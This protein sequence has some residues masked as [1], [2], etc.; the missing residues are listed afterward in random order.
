MFFITIRTPFI[1]CSN[2]NRPHGN[3]SQDFTL[4]TILNSKSSI[5]ASPFESTLT[6]LDKNNKIVNF[7]LATDVSLL[8][9]SINSLPRLLFWYPSPLKHLFNKLQNVQ[10]LIIFW[11][12]M[13]VLPG[14]KLM[15]FQ[16]ISYMHSIHHKPTL[17]HHL[18]LAVPWI[19]WFGS[20]GMWN[21]CL[22]WSYS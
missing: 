10:L 14:Q 19:M 16:R 2:E 18:R 9:S 1:H 17:S 5:F 15:L 21:I 12:L 3:V 13:A 20:L 7:I 22:N 11:V 4:S 8:N 6:T